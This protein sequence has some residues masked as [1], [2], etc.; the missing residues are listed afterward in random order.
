MRAILVI[1]YW[2]VD[3]SLPALRLFRLLASVGLRKTAVNQ[4][5]MSYIRHIIA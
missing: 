3:R 4:Y 5:L 2:P 1:V